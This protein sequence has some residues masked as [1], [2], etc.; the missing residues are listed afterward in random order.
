MTDSATVL[1]CAHC[2]A[3]HV[4]EFECLELDKEAS[5]R[6]DACGHSFTFLIREC[7]ECVEVSVWTWIKPPRKEEVDRLVCQAC[8]EPF[9]EEGQENLDA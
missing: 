6:C 1:I 8:G 7:S 5:M 9:N 3:H 2:A 4:D